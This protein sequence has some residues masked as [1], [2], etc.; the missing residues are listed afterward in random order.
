VLVVTS[1]D[2]E[3]LLEEDA[4]VVGLPNTAPSGAD[5]A[6]ERVAPPLPAVPLGP[7]PTE[8]VCEHNP[9]FPAKPTAPSGRRICSPPRKA[10]KPW[11]LQLF[12]ACG[13]ADVARWCLLPCGQH[14]TISC[15]GGGAACP[16]A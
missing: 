11:Q 9:P 6:A 15:A 8:E 5:A 13:P 4:V 2:E 3:L 16:L 10:P 14:A 7:P 1:D 12:L